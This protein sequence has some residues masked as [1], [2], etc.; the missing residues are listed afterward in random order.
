M[1]IELVDAPFDQ[2]IFPLHPMAV[3]VVLVPAQIVS[4]PLMVG[5]LGKAFTVIFTTV[6][7]L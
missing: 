1:L 5:I 2:V 7:I 6:E 3:K 4:P